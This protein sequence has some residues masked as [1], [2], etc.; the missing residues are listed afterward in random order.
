LLGLTPVETAHFFRQELTLHSLPLRFALACLCLLL[1]ACGAASRNIDSAALP[2]SY[3]SASDYDPQAPVLQQTYLDDA[4]ASSTPLSA[5]GFKVWAL[6][7]QG[8]VD[9]AAQSA[10]KLSGDAGSLT[11]SAT[12]P[13]RSVSLYVG[14]DA[15]KLHPTSMDVARADGVSL[16]LKVQPG[17]LAIGASA[18]GE[19]TLS[20]AT[21]LARLR[22]AAGAD[23]ATVRT[24]STSQTPANAVKNLTATDGHN[25]TAT[26]QWDE[27]HTGDYDLNGEVNISDLTPLGAK[28]KQSYDIG[29][30]DL[31]LQVI[32]GDLNGELNISDLTPIGANFRSTIIGYNVYRTPLTDLAEE[33]DVAETARWTKVPNAAE[34]AGPSAPREFNGQK[35]R[36]TYTFVDASGDGPFAWYVAV[37]A[38]ADNPPAE[39]KPSNVAKVE[40]TPAGPPP[41]GLSFE[42]IAPA[43]ETVATNA[44]FYLAVK[45]TGV[46]DLFSANVRFEYDNALVEFVEGV[47]AY[48]DGT[49][50]V[51]FLEPP[52]FIAADDVDTA[53]A[54]FTLLGFNATQTQGTAAKTGEGYLGYFK[55]KALAAGDSLE[56]FRF[57]QA[58]NFIYLWGENYGESIATPALGSPQSLTVT[59]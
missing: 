20:T 4:L 18:Y 39:G 28:F 14:Y 31:Q 24:P 23:T 12:R 58:S 51:N 3:R 11:I 26:L 55:F 9:S 59:P 21:P 29:A 2:D 16:A 1:T 5:A 44:E 25:S 13:L 53:P 22:F 57:P 10:L 8:Q 32:D 50:H 34:P 15:G 54:G 7:A 33:P 42:I 35:V 41:A 37:A 40:V 46:T 30:P 27:I 38:R 48:D 52:L 49:P 36:L 56:A 17:L 43:T 45:V 6:T 47:P 19:D